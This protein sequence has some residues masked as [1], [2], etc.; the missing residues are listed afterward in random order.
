MRK[1]RNMMEIFK[2]TSKNLWAGKVEEDGLTKRV[3]SILISN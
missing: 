3:T 2:Q 1:K